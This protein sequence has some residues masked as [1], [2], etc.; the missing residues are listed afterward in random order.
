M[1]QSYIRMFSFIISF[2][3]YLLYVVLLF[4]ILS[5]SSVL[6]TKWQKKSGGKHDGLCAPST[7][8]KRHLPYVLVR[9]LHGVLLPHRKSVGSYE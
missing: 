4:C 6:V 5:H 2:V 3:Q 8:A 9:I 7:V 1:C